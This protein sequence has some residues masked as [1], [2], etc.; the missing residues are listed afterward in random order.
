MF[1]T[2]LNLVEKKTY[3]L[4]YCVE[5]QKDFHNVHQAIKLTGDLWNGCRM[6]QLQMYTMQLSCEVVCNYQKYREIAPE[7]SQ[8]F[9]Y[10]YISKILTTV[11]LHQEAI[12]LKN[13]C[14]YLSMH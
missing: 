4:T 10:K 3:L 5:T 2:C 8:E 12:R 13:N 11:G 14:Q 7:H 9:W 1:S 6:P